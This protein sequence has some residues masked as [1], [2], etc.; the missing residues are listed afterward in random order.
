MLL[1]GNHTKV[2][3]QSFAKED[4]SGFLPGFDRYGDGVPPVFDAE[5]QFSRNGTEVLAPDPSSEEGDIVKGLAGFID[6]PKGTEAAASRQDVLLVPASDRPAVESDPDFVK[7]P[8]SPTLP[9]FHPIGEADREGGE[10]ER[11]PSNRRFTCQPI[12]EED[13]QRRLQKL[14]HPVSRRGTPKPFSQAPRNVDR[15][16]PAVRSQRLR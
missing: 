6:L 9:S 16:V 11:T 13:G 2:T 10:P 4:G 14:G 15:R 7:L 5:M 8:M 3:V 1:L 12:G